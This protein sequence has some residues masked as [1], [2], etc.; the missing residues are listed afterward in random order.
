MTSLRW[1][2]VASLLLAILFAPIA[3]ADDFYTEDLRIPTAAAR[4][5]GARKPSS[6]APAAPG[7]Y[8][9]ALISHGTPRDVDD[10]TG[11]ER[12]ADYRAIAIEFAR[13]GVCGAG[14]V[15]RR[16]YG[17]SPGGAR[18]QLRLLQESRLSE[19]AGGVGCGPASRD[20]GD[21]EPQ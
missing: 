4:S 11:H 13:R 12:G 16:G 14:G 10:R 2:T 1:W 21:Q 5:R 19:C 6:C 20:R 18:R 15:L 7:P 9:L 3:R 8:P 17:S